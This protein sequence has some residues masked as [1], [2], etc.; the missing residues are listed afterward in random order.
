MTL[1]KGSK[2]NSVS[3]NPNSKS[4]RKSGRWMYTYRP[5]NEWDSKV[6]KGPFSYLKNEM[7]DKDVYD[8]SY[9]T[10]KELKMPTAQERLDEF[11]NLYTDHKRRTV[12]DLQ[13]EQN[14]MKKYDIGPKDVQDVDLKNLSTE[15]DYKRAY[16][17]FNHAMENSNEFKSTKRYSEIMSTKYDAMIDDNNLDV[18]N[19]AEE[20]III[21]RPEEVLTEIGDT[22]YVPVDEISANTEEVQKELNRQGREMLI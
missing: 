5:E 9:E 11:V 18:Y 21:F 14:A 15:K 7:T 16:E 19:K 3:V 13:N 20:P 6:Y 4:Y 8:H 1:P 12:K 17:I 10:V 2:L 22:R